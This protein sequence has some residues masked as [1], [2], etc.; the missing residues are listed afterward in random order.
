MAMPELIYEIAFERNPNAANPAWTNVTRFVRKVEESFVERGRSYELDEIQPG[1]G[2][3]T[4]H[5]FAGEFTPGNALSPYHPWVL[6]GRRVRIRAV[7]EAQTRTLL[8]AAVDSF[9]I[10]WPSPFGRH[11]LCRVAA[12]D[13]LG[14]LGRHELRSQ[15]EEET[16]ALGQ[17]TGLIAYYPLT[18]DTDSAAAGDITEL[19]NPSLNVTVKGDA[20]VVSFGAELPLLGADGQ[21]GYAAGQPGTLASGRFAGSWLQGT[22]ATPIDINGNF[23]VSLWVIVPEVHPVSGQPSGLVRL[24]PPA[25]ASFGPFQVLVSMLSAGTV[26][27]LIGSASSGGSRRVD[28]GR[29]HHVVVTVANAGGSDRTISIWVDG[30]LDTQ[31]T[32]AVTTIPA[33]SAEVYVGSGFTFTG[34]GTGTI[35]FTFEGTI[36]HVAIF[37]STLDAAGVQRIH[38]T[39]ADGLPGEDTGTRAQRIAGY[40]GLS[41]GAYDR[42]LSNLG[43]QSLAGRSVAE[44]WAELAATEAAPIYIGADGTPRAHT[45]GRRRNAEPA[46]VLDTARK[47]YREIPYGSDKQLLVNDLTY[48]GAGGARG[49]VV[50]SDSI[51]TFGRYRG[52]PLEL[53]LVSEF[54]ARQRA[55]G[56]LKDYAQ[57]GVRAKAIVVTPSAVPEL[58]AAML[59]AGLS[60][61]FTTINLPATHPAPALDYLVEHVRHSWTETEWTTTMRGSPYDRTP[62]FQADHPVYGRLDATNLIGW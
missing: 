8:D 1:S 9:D 17:S 11:T 2:G 39:G 37:N 53:P 5:N 16:L 35:A 13:T 58:F 19:D 59:D 4:L 30:K 22:L 42:G 60:Q 41:G 40:A 28:D 33:D 31:N 36:G 61:R 18:E 54:E 51:D 24:G 47:H 56:R 45:R 23:T 46:F 21:G 26:D 14:P 10:E 55:L 20:G 62:Y 44:V 29:V 34:A 43:A 12:T 48:T 49:R 57:P 38:R 52:D 25:S 50:D 27:V 7:H 15:L 3:F 6:P 32:V